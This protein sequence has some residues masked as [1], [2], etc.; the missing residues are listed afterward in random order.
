[1]VEEQGHCVV[2]VDMPVSQRQVHTTFARVFMRVQTRNTGDMPTEEKLVGEA[3]S[4]LVWR[5]LEW[6]V[7]FACPKLSRSSIRPKVA[8]HCPGHAQQQRTV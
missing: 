8:F 6:I 4:H 2:G 3:L 5:V 7:S 1:M